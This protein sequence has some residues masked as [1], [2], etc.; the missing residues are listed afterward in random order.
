[1]TDT[2]DQSILWRGVFQIV[3]AYALFA[4]LWIL[5]S[6]RAMGLMFP[7]HDL[8]VQAS[9]IKGW[10]F[11]AVTS[12]LLYVLVRRFVGQL[13][14]AHRREMAAHAGQQRTL[15]LLTTLVEGSDDAIFAKDEEGR[16]LLF[17]QAAAVF[18]G[19]KPAEVLGQ[20][21]RAIFPADQAEMLMAIGRRVMATGQIE[22]NEETIDTARGQGTFLATKGPL[23][24]ETGR[25]IGIFGISRDITE[26]KQA[27]EALRESETRFRALVEQSLAGIYIIQDGRF[28]YVNPG[29][30]VIFGYDS[31]AD[32]VAGISVADLVAPGDRERVSENIRRRIHGE[33]G[34]IHYTFLGRRRDGSPIDVEVHGR[35]FDY[36]GRPAVIGVIL[37]ITARKAAEDALRAS[38][39]RFHDIVRATADWVWEVD[40]E[41][42]YTYAS[43]SVH[44]FLGYTPQE[45]LGKTPFDLM[46]PD[47]ATRVGKLFTDIVARQESFRDLDNLNVRKDGSMVLVSTNGMPILD[48]DGTL[49]GYRG[50][51]RD[52]TEQKRAE[53]ELRAR[54]EELER[55]NRATVGRELKMIELKR[56]LNA[57]ARDL[58]RPAPYDL[59][60][61]DQEDGGG[62]PS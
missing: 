10:F 30:A 34:D 5:L 29:F 4:G 15:Q 9:M 39:L 35:R 8:L 49:L 56:E 23:R 48:A 24:D 38:E 42:R 25:I 55:F 52:I 28:R 36:E 37:D 60:F 61:V 59:S 40:A 26:R 32:I 20:D 19:K 57:L 62:Q 12:L 2:N 17:N 14:A 47:E 21:D 3:L 46:P 43:E 13:Q 16:Y 50:L 11:V 33:T 45:I 31:A 6:D 54:N 18:V 41:A 53:L 51:D 58:G 27:E 22:T 1:M 44:E 7:D